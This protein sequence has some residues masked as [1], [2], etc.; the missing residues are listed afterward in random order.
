MFPT[1]QFKIFSRCYLLY[2]QIIPP[3]KITTSVCFNKRKDDVYIQRM[4]QRFENCQKIFPH[5]DYPLRMDPKYKVAII[6]GGET[7]IGLAAA[8]DLLANEAQTVVLAGVCEGEVAVKKL[9]E[10]YG[11]GRACFMHMDVNDPRDF[12]ELFYRVNLVYGGIDIVFNNAG[13]LQDH[14]WEF[15]VD[16]NLKSVIRGTLLGLDYMGKN[17]RGKRKGDGIIINHSD[18]MALEGLPYA[19]A[20]S[21]T[22]AG[23]I[24]ATLSFGAKYHYNHTG[25]RVVGLLSGPTKTDI[26]QMAGEKQLEPEWGRLLVAYLSEP[27]PQ[28]ATVAGRAVTY[29]VKYATP[30]SLWTIDR[31]ELS[32]TKIPKRRDL[33]TKVTQL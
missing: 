12:E 11:Q 25:V 28:S 4:A 31:G 18:T 33:N 14:V 6:T 17:G 29:L 23:I 27:P 24:G 19:P 30:G 22:K 2:K 5:Y 13:I 20:Y 3:R 21:A 9:N 32:I 15:E 8:S 10:D 7:G 26:I 1:R 16:T